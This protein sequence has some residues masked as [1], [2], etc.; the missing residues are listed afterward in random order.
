MGNNFI[1]CKSIPRDGT[2]GKNCPLILCSFS[3]SIADDSNGSAARPRTTPNISR[4]L[5][6]MNATRRS[7]LMCKLVL[8]FCPNPWDFPLSIPNSYLPEGRTAETFESSCLQGRASPLQPLF[9]TYAMLLLP[10]ELLP[11]P[12]W[13]PALQVWI[14]SEILAELDWSPDLNNFACELATKLNSVTVVSYSNFKI[15]DDGSS[16][17]TGQ[18]LFRRTYAMMKSC[19]W[20]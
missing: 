8:G 16:S 14:E 12:L 19:V 2:Y 7:L 1:G 5:T 15:G 18:Y 9:E 13:T 10:K 20:Q 11:C 17:L 6:L 4:S 3:R